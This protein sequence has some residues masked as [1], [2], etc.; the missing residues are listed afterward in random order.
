MAICP[1]HGMIKWMDEHPL[2][3]ETHTPKPAAPRKI[4]T[5]A[6]CLVS[7]LAIAAGTL[8]AGVYMNRDSQAWQRILG[9]EPAPEVSFT[10]GDQLVPILDS[11]GL[12]N[13]SN[14][15]GGGAALRA[16]YTATQVMLTKHVG[17]LTPAALQP[18]AEPEKD[19]G[20]ATAPPVVPRSPAAA[21]ELAQELA[22][23]GQELVEAAVQA[24]GQRARSLS[25]AG[26]EIIMQARN[27][28]KAAGGTQAQLDAL[29]APKLAA[30]PGSDTAGD[31]AAVP[32]L[33]LSSC[34]LAPGADAPAP[35]S[36]KA[37]KASAKDTA[38]PGSGAA[39]GLV[40]DAAY[41]L[42][43]A[44]NVAEART[45][46]TLRASAAARSVAM[47]KLGSSIEEQF[48]T[49]GECEPLR[50]PAYLLPAGAAT[51]P[52]DTAHNGEEQLALLLRDAAATQ[53][54]ETRAFLLQRAWDQ[55]L[56]T[57]QVTGKI[58]GFTSLAADSAGK[59]TTSPQ[60]IPTP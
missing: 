58:P 25:G 19:S 11:V 54:G 6:V 36:T 13:A 45:A 33:L 57:R 9:T 51:H 37:T 22:V 28:L 56:Y 10:P 18:P 60:A 7:T 52:M 44:Y 34:P 39:L 15:T 53:E 38:L 8:G 32:P 46:G 35:T 1:G 24:P 55:G 20:E 14:G 4:G 31:P 59:K 43:Y 3:P 26:F 21:K 27:L 30:K 5:L 16:A 23:A 17:L 50:Q 29:P 2:P 49:V 47:A 42:S 41:R 48:S 12:T 40:A